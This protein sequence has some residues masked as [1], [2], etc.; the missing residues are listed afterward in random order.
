[1]NRFIGIPFSDNKESF[2]GANC[3]G[4]ARL[5]YK[6]ELG[7]I[8]NELNVPSAHSNKVF[9]TFLHEISKDWEEIEEPEFGC[10]V[11]MAHD[12]AHPKIVQHVGIYVGDGKIIHTINKLDSHVSKLEML[13]PIIR[14]FYKW[15]H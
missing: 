4:L 9:A 13:K 14:G 10:I 1:M 8:I 12:L 6:E 2:E 15:R 5:F 7:I 11:A 3:Y